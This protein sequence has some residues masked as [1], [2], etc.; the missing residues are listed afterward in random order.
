[1]AAIGGFRQHV[2]LTEILETFPW[3]FCFPKSRINENGGNY[4]LYDIMSLVSSSIVS[5]KKRI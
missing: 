4:I 2:R 3:V 5:Q 1:M